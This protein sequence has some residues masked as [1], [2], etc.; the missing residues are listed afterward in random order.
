MKKSI[1]KKQNG[2]GGFIAKTRKRK[3][4]RGRSKKKNKKHKRKRCKKGRFY[5]GGAGAA[6]PE[7]TISDILTYAEMPFTYVCNL[8]NQNVCLLY[9]I[10][11]ILCCCC[12]LRLAIACC[13]RHCRTPN[14]GGHQIIPVQDVDPTAIAVEI[15]NH[16]PIRQD[17]L[18]MALQLIEVNVEVRGD[19]III[20]VHHGDIPLATLATLFPDP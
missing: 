2:G 17:V 7:N 16:E 15:G 1:G 14:R 19:D 6:A 20:N 9:L 18:E 3:K 13:K 5:L 4:A 11:L 12:A 10:L 8:G